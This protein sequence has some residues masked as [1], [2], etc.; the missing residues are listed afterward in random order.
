MFINLDE[1]LGKEQSRLFT[2]KKL[3]QEQIDKTIQKQER[4]EKLKAFAFKHGMLGIEEIADSRIER[5]EKKLIVNEIMNY[6][7]NSEN[8]EKCEI[9]DFDENFQDDFESEM[10]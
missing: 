4:A 7:E 1:T 9:E 3:T 10:L 8:N 6:I 2:G 5:C